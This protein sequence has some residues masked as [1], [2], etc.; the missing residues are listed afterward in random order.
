MRK[1]MLSFVIAAVLAPSVWAQD[2]P[3]AE[4]FAGFSILSVEIEE[5]D[6]EALYGWQAS[7]AGNPT[8]V[9]GLVADFGG[10]YKTIEG[11]KVKI[12]EFLFGPRVTARGERANGFAHFLLGGARASGGGESE[13]GFMLGIGG[14]VDIKAGENAAIRIIQFDW[15]PARFQG[16]WTRDAVRIGIGVVFGGGS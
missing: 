10:Q 16:E 8:P 14:G 9:L 4:V 11:E 5:S 13:N 15:T 1:F 12:H 3:K 7:V 2:A 6:R